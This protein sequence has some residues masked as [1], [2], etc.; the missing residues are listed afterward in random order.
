M[1][2]DVFSPPHPESNCFHSLQ[3][4]QLQFEP[5]G[6]GVANANTLQRE[7]HQIES[8]VGCNRLSVRVEEACSP[9]VSGFFPSS[10]R[11][12]LCTLLGNSYS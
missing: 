2:T 12:Y 4:E 8:T 5:Q 1:E 3:K 11:C 10:Y 7:G 9:P 6:G